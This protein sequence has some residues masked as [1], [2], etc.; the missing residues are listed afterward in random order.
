MNILILFGQR[1]ES[2]PGQYLP[3]A[4]AIIDETG[5]E[6]NPDY[7]KEEF[8]KHKGYN[9]FDALKVITISISDDKLNKA[10]Y[11]TSRILNAKI[12]E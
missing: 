12:I 2:Y 10:L 5:N 6:D 4:L 7:M 1:K 8:E 9:D 3:E 11:P